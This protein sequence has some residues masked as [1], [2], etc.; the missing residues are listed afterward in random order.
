[1]Q[2]SLL[3]DPV[4]HWND[5][6]EVALIELEH[7][8]RQHHDLDVADLHHVARHTSLRTSRG[9]NDAQRRDCTGDDPPTPAQGRREILAAWSNGSRCEAAPEGGMRAVLRVR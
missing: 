1:M 3:R 4:V 6:E 9:I 7:P 2:M 8:D 5:R